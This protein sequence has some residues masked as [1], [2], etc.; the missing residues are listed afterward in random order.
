MG[1]RSARHTGARLALVGSA[2]L[3][4]AFVS[5][6][7][8]QVVSRAA[9]SAVQPHVDRV[10]AR[11]TAP[12]LGGVDVPNFVFER[13]LSFQARLEALADPRFSPSVEEP[14]QAIHVRNALERHIAEAILE[15]LQMTPLPTPAEIEQR[16]RAAEASLVKNVGGRAALSLAARSEG[17]AQREVYRLIQRRARASLYLDRMVAPMLYPSEA[18]LQS[19][20]GTGRTPFSREN[21]ASVAREVRGWYVS[22]SLR[23]AVSAYYEGARTRIQLTII[24]PR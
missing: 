21:Y 1:W 13:E 6:A 10:V 2:V 11:F 8:A 22:R 14:Y 7:S 12:E 17:L 24:D 18:E 19:L 23:Q 15:S 3:G 4:S 16:A 5:H 9:G 20:H